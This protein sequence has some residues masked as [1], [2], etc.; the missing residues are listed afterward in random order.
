MR[1][2]SVATL[3]PRYDAQVF[4]DIADRHPRKKSLQP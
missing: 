3:R 4:K 1:V 2:A